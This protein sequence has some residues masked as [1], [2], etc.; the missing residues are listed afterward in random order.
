MQLT[1]GQSII[2]L[3]ILATP[4][5]SVAHLVAVKAQLLSRSYIDDIRSGMEGKFFGQLT[6][7]QCALRNLEA[8]GSITFISAGSVRVALPGTVGLAAINGAIEAIVPTLAKELAP[9]RVNAVSPGV[10]DT[11]WW[12]AIPKET[13]KIYLDKRQN[14]YP[15]VELAVLK[16]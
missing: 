7:A 5:T 13:K 15:F 10:I 2:S 14:V 6:V 16:M 9:T 11:P 4:S 3:S 1:E 8:G 12:N